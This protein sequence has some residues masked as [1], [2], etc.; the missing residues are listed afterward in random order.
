MALQFGQEDQQK[1]NTF[2][3]LNAQLHELEALMNVQQVRLHVIFAA[4]QPSCHDPWPHN[5]RNIV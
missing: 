5:D 1:I 2:S 3:R 4:A